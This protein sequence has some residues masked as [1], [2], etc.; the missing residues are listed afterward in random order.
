MRKSII[1]NTIF[2]ST[3]VCIFYV[4]WFIQQKTFVNPDVSWLFEASKRMLLGGTYSQNYYENNPP[5]VLYLMLP[6]VFISRMVSINFEIAIRLY[7][8]F[9][10][11]LSLVLSGSLLKKILKPSDVVLRLAL[12]LLLSFLY[13]IIPLE[14][15]GQREHLL[16]MLF[17]PYMLLLVCRAESK[18]IKSELAFF[19]GI[20][21][22][23]GMML[24]PYFFFAPILIEIY[25]L[26][27][28]KRFSFLIRPENSAILLMLA[29]YALIIFSFHQDYLTKIVPF[30]MRWCYFGT[31]DLRAVLVFNWISIT[32][33]SAIFTYFLI[34]KENNYLKLTRV[35]LLAMVG[36]FVSYLIQQEPWFYHLMPAYSL[37]IFIFFLLVFQFMHIYY[38]KLNT[39]F[40]LKFIK[41][42]LLVILS[43]MFLLVV[44]CQVSIDY[45]IKTEKTASY[46]A[47]LNYITKHAKNERV[48]VLSTNIIHTYPW[49]LMS[50]G[51]IPASRFSFLWFLPGMI[52]QEYYFMTPASRALYLNDRAF[53]VNLICDDITLQKP[54][55]IIVDVLKRKNSLTW[56]GKNPKV[57]QLNYVDYFSENTRFKECWKHYR[58]K[59]NINS[60]YYNKVKKILVPVYSFDVYERIE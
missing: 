47:Y 56:I 1:K 26:M 27:E 15:F 16:I 41:F 54:K 36:F 24:K 20:I 40:S 21:A 48:Y 32:F 22:S 39:P 19:I 52:K 46:K 29:G 30:A 6:S 53:V 7:V 10:A 23:A 50:D 2:Y 12:I 34:K 3:L 17:M 13:M 51:V 33:F 28:K 31:R 25:L 37:S 58:F 38:R 18:K 11:I 44:Y 9:F 8:V 35:A 60:A 49:V 5:W 4:G 57:I 45:K 59:E 14:E 55:L 42:V 43:S